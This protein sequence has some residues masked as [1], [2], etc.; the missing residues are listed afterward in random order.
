MPKSG[1][2]NALAGL[3]FCRQQLA[4]TMQY[5]DYLSVNQHFTPPRFVAFLIDFL[6]QNLH[7]APFRNMEHTP[8]RSL[9]AARTACGCMVVPILEDTDTD[10]Y[11]DNII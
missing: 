2:N 10:K 7:F 9:T 3:R 1:F 8:P 5:I 11:T 4:H 6:F